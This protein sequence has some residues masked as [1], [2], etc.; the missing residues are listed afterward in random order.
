MTQ[1]IRRFPVGYSKEMGE[2]YNPYAFIPPS[3]G[4]IGRNFVGDK[5]KH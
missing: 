1:R 3:K 2:R 4:L 5:F